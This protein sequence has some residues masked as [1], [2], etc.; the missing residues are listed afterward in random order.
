[1]RGMQVTDDVIGRTAL[2]SL[3]VQSLPEQE[4]TEHA[5]NYA[6]KSLHRLSGP[7][8]DEAY[9][10]LTKLRKPPRPSLSCH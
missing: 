6:A 5:T 4:D 8:P 7:Y 1:V 2:R 9:S 10:V 3:I